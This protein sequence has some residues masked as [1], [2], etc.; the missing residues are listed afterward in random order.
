MQGQW[1]RHWHRHR[2]RHRHGHWH[3][4]WQ[5][6][7]GRDTDTDT[8]TD[9]GTTQ[10]QT[11]TQAQTQTLSCSTSTSVA[12]TLYSNTIKYAEIRVPSSVFL[13]FCCCSLFPLSP[14]KAPLVNVYRYNSITSQWTEQ[15]SNELALTLPLSP[16]PHTTLPKLPTLPTLP[17]PHTQTPYAFSLQISP[18]TSFVLP[19]T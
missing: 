5:G 16:A 14:P 10:T 2:Y 6:D 17:I 11:R 3:R 13:F 7:K 8:G 4:H 1:H 18:P 15:K 9:T 19:S 12:N